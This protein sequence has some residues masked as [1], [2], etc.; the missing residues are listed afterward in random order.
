[1]HPRPVLM[2]LLCSA[3][4]A[5]S[6]STLPEP[7]MME[8]KHLEEGYRVL[9]FAADKVWS[10]WNGYRKVP[11]LMQFEN[12]LRVLVGHPNPPKPFQTVPDV[13]VEDRA[14]F[15]DW[16]A[17]SP[18]PLVGPLAAGG[19]LIPFGT[20]SAGNRIEVVRLH[21]RSPQTAGESS[22]ASE[23]TERQILIF[24]HELF[25]CFQRERLRGR[26]YGNLRYNAD[27]NYTV[28][29]EIEGLALGRAYAEPDAARAREYLRDFLAAR[30]KKRAGSMTPL[31]G[32]QEGF[33]EF[34]EGT[35]TYSE[36]RTLEL[37]KAGGFQ[38]ALK[39]DPY[40]R[41]FT[42]V[43]VL[44]S[45]FPK[46]L[47]QS[48]ERTEDPKMKSYQF[49]CF[50]AALLQRLFPGWQEFVPRT[51][52][53][54]DG[55]IARRLA[56]PD[57]DWPKLEQRLE[58]TYPSA[59]I[60]RRHAPVIAARDEA[61]RKLRSRTG[62]V[63]VIDC[64]KTG[65]YLDGVAARGK[66]QH[67]GLVTMYPEGFETYRFDEVEIGAIATPAEVDQLYYIRAVDT[68]A[69]PGAAPY[70]VEGTRQP[71]GTW[72]Q[73][74]V[75]TPLFTVKAPHV[76]MLEAGSLVKVQVLARVKQ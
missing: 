20:D 75:H 69:R 71:D 72:T 63:Y 23:G 54:L 46:Q 36:L 61:W 9:D 8:L 21:Y 40:Y 27:V 44:L 5:H 70:S 31:Q 38:P 4:V 11:F 34:N 41:G 7:V 47:K 64:K 60:R 25:H 16:S 52:E 24:I 18:K 30:R 59:D 53:S 19:G 68:E 14:V 50:Q 42:A 51:V 74:I 17:V 48:A 10:G 67:M 66:P 6:A 12:G 55:E 13:R 22:A 1:M 45:G 2:L 57:E 32:N 39:D 56:V 49:G 3:A 33:D 43:D 15:A 58:E 65:Q 28:Y 73:A 35:A 26:M 29:S 37:I 76:R 62:R